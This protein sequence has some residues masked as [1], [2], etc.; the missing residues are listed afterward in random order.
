M[1]LSNSTFQ[2]VDF[3]NSNFTGANLTGGYFIMSKFSGT[4]LESADMRDVDDFGNTFS[5]AIYKNT[6]MS[7]GTIKIFP[8][9]LRTTR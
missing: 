8:C 1:N 7:D 2:N 5:G 3:S 6:I 4:N 9:R